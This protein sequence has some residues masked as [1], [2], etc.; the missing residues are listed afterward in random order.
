MFIEGVLV[1]LLA[2]KSELGQ[3]LAQQYPADVG[4]YPVM[5]SYELPAT[6]M[7]AENE[8]DEVNWELADLTG[9]P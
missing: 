8:A 5:S 7:F 9:G 2:V 1:S 3:F 4:K 6:D